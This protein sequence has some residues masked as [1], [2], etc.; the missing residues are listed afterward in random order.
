MMIIKYND[1][2]I[3]YT[4]RWNIN[5]FSATSTA[6]GNYFEF[7]YSGECAVIGFDTSYARIPFPHIYIS[8]DGGA[9]VEV[10]LDRFI[11]ISAEEGEHRVCVILKGLFRMHPPAFLP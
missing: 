4:G 2:R 3:R 9:N 8:V 6:N 11:R 5:E 7:M 1:D 10:S